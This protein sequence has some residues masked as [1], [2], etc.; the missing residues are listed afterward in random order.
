VI[1]DADAL[2]TALINLLDNAYKYSGDDKQVTLSASAQNGSV[3]FAVKDNGIGLSQRET[4]RIFKRFYQV[5]QRMSRPVGGC[6]LGLS[7]VKF[8]VSAHHG[9]IKVESEP[10]QGSTFTLIL[11]AANSSN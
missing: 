7:I 3:A 9:Q 5:D 6:G 2:V 11:P 8:I 1:A 10:S 4:K